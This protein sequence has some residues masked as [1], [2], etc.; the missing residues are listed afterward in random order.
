MTRALVA[1]KETRLREA[2]RMMGLPT[3]VNWL[4]WFMKDFTMLMI[5]VIFIV[6]I[7][8]VGDVRNCAPGVRPGMLTLNHCPRPTAARDQQFKLHRAD[9]SHILRCIRDC[10]RVRC[11]HGLQ[12][13][14][15]RRYRVSTG[16]LSALPTVPGRRGLCPLP[17]A[18]VLV[19]SSHVPRPSVVHGHWV[20]RSYACANNKNNTDCFFPGR[21]SCRSLKAVEWGSN[22]AT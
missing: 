2:M 18:L 9:F 14:Q 5:T 11:V 15:C 7:F 12:P 3:W 20:S 19:Q 4:A 6:I 22:W 8:N 13:L 17:T 16:I 1:E 10:V 21:A